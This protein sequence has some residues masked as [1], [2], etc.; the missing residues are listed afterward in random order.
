MK[1]NILLVCIAFSAILFAACGVKP[2]LAGE[3]PTSSLPV[4]ND[5][6]DMVRLFDADQKAAACG[7]AE[8]CY[9][10]CFSSGTSTTLLYYVDYASATQ[11]P[12]C[13]A[14][15]C[16][17]DNETCTAV[18]GGA[19]IFVHKDK[20]YLIERPLE[21]AERLWEMELDGSGRHEVLVLGNG[22]QFAYT[23]IT[24]NDNAIF[25]EVL[26]PEED[27]G[28]NSNYRLCRYDLSSKETRTLRQSQG[29]NE[30]IMGVCGPYMV[31]K[32]FTFDNATLQ[33]SGNRF[34]LLDATGAEQEIALPEQFKDATA[35]SEYVADN[36]IYLLDGQQGNLSAVDPIS[37]SCTELLREETLADLSGNPHIV[38]A[39]E[40]KFVLKV[41]DEYYLYADGR[42]LKSTCSYYR[43]DT[44]QSNMILGEYE[45]QYLVGRDLNLSPYRLEL[46][47]KTDYWED[48]M[49]G[50]PIQG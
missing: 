43:S 1:R 41:A 10:V 32:T 35:V 16:T 39:I 50:S 20:L 31:M 46:V 25:F 34:Y 6:G 3:Q 15:N 4:E 24:G 42:F 36:K 48:I 23:G 7:T 5:G 17:H 26:T 40:G 49:S 33:T 44:K 22:E 19:S 9:Q 21:A 12:L 2:K 38:N 18:V 37:Q 13:T 11:F 30:F 27:A 47:R 28:F 8:G 45:D 29:T 14:P